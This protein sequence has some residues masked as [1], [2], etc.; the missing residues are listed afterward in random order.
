[1][2]YIIKLALIVIGFGSKHDRS[3]TCI[4]P[5]PCI[6]SIPIPVGGQTSA[7]LFQTKTKQP[8]PPKLNPLRIFSTA[9]STFYF[10]LPDLNKYKS[11]N[12]AAH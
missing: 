7:P 4:D 10:T 1:M 6:Y 9:S 2:G 11:S 3:Y 8:K 5:F 12:N